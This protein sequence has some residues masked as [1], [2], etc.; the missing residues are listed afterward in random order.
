MLALWKR[1]I[2]S[3]TALLLDGTGLGPDDLLKKV[4]EFEGVS[5][6]TEHSIPALVLSREE[7]G[8]SMV[9]LEHE[10]DVYSDGDAYDEDEDTLFYD[11]D[12]SAPL[13]SLPIDRI[14]NKLSQ[15]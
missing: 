4:E 12:S 3:R 10:D 15:D 14:A 7:D 9:E 1:A 6:A 5:Q 13:G 2:E 8:S 11:S